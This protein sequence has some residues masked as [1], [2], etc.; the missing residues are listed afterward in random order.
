MPLF[1]PVMTA[2]FPSN[3]PIGVSFSFALTVSRVRRMRFHFVGTET[4]V[5]VGDSP[6]LVGKSRVSRGVAPFERI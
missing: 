4:F 2:T 6:G 5:H 1:P 3:L